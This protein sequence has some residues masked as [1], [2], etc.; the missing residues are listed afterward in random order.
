GATARIP[1]LVSSSLRHRAFAL[2]AEFPNVIDQLPK[3]FTP[4]LLKSGV[5]NALATGALVVQAQWTGCAMP[6]SVESE[7]EATLSGDASAF[8]VRA[9]LDFLNQSQ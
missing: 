5:A 4:E 3:P 8:S 7:V 6:E 1:V 2:Y 9:L